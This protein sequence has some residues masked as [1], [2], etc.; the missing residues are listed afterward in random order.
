MMM[1][2]L[3]L[4]TNKLSSNFIRNGQ[5]LCLNIK[6]FHLKLCL[7]RKPE[8]W[9]EVKNWKLLKKDVKCEMAQKYG[10]NSHFTVVETVG[11]QKVKIC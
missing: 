3:N 2:W 4:L 7:T 11:I 9:Q 5:A 10:F 1:E 6:K 8:Q